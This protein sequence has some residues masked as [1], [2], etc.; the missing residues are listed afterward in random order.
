MTLEQD[1]DMPIY[2]LVSDKFS[3]NPQSQRAIRVPFEVPQNGAIEIA[4]I[5][6]SQPLKIP[7]GRFS[8]YFETH[9]D[10]SQNMVGCFTFCRDFTK[11]PEI[12]KA[13][14]KLVTPERYQMQGTS[15]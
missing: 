11:M 3:L 9:L 7:S 14:T 15:A 10:Q 13:D 8:L 2:L 6:D 1:G 4:S 12:I 5:S